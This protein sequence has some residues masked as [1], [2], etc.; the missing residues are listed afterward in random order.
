MATVTGLT[1]AKQFTYRGQSGEEFSNT[2]HFKSAP[3][4]SD[5]SWLV[6]LNEVVAFEKQVFPADVTYSHARGYDSNDDHAVHVFAHDFL[7]PG[8][9]PV[10]TYIPDGIN[11]NGIAGDQA[12][13]VSWPTDKKSVRGKTVYLRKY[14]HDGFVESSNSD[15]VSPAWLAVLTTFATNMRTVH[16]GLR[17][18]LNDLNVTGGFGSPFITTRTLK[19]RGKKKLP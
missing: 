5:S 9:P 13:M 17:S 19:R 15:M 3:P 4:A 12:G 16:G 6:L 7:V 18:A 10:G 11:D 1:I 14:F 2:Y 8:P